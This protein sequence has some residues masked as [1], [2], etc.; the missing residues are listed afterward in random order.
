MA[1]PSI[2]S[3]YF[4]V[5]LLEIGT[6]SIFLVL[7]NI[8]VA[9]GGTDLGQPRLHLFADSAL[10]STF[11]PRGRGHG[12]ARHLICLQ[13]I[14]AY[15]PYESSEVPLNPIYKKTNSSWLSLHT[16]DWIAFTILIYVIGGV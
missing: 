5:S 3:T 10:L 1:F 8:K 7:F 15:M 13:C 11:R 12:Q 6:S 9:M 4:G 2:F 16:T 14:L